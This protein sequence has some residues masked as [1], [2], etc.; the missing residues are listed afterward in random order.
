MIPAA[1]GFLSGIAGMA[2]A[3][4]LLR[5]RTVIGALAG[6]GWGA[7]S[8]DTS[9]L[10]GALMGAAGARYLGAGIKRMG[11]ARGFGASARAFGRGAM[12]R[13]RLDWRGVRMMSNRGM[14]RIGS[15]L[16]GWR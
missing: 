6:A 1:G 7:M 14:S 10:G 8:N 9:V 4:S 2:G 3:A 12:N 5:N 13:A 15:T 16:K 11:I